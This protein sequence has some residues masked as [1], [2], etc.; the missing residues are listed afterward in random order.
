MEKA[1]RRLKNVCVNTPLMRSIYFSNRHEASIHLKRED[2]Q[3]VRSYKIRGAYIKMKSLTKEQQVN[4]VVCASAGNHA[5]GVAHSCHHLKVMGT[6]FMPSTTPNQKIEQVRMF[7]GEYVNIRLEG[8]TFDDAYFAAEAFCSKHKSEFIHPFNDEKV[9]EGQS[10]IGLEI[11]KQATEPIDYLII[12][13]GGGG[14]AA[15]I[16]TVFKWMS[17]HTKLIGVEPAGAASMQ[18][19]FDHGTNIPLDK[20]DKF[21]DGA[22]VKQV[23]EIPYMI[24]KDALDRMI[25]IPEG[26]ICEMIL[27]LYNKE[28]IIAEPAGA[29]TISALDF[30]QDEIKGKNV[31]CILSGGNNDITRMEEIKERALVY[32]DLK[33][34]FLV[35]FPQRSGALKEFVNQVLGKDDDITFFEYA[36]KNSRERGM[37]VVGVE[38]KDKKDFDPLLVR[39][40]EHKFFGDYLNEKPELLRFLY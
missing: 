24:C 37:A 11:L 29:L 31:V 17:P 28:A 2:L 33:H 16:S 9:I 1:A 23:G 18:Y 3:T 22:A 36:K 10:T 19:A 5:Q 15:G 7:G 13:V 32:Q 35:N 20:I 30:L 40:N 14:L 39:M 26:K 21:V 38:L 6:I 8:D 34:Y 12:P 4:G 27:T 25:S